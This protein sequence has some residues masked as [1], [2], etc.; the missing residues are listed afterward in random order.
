MSEKKNTTQTLA[1][2]LLHQ[3]QRRRRRY[4]HTMSENAT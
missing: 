3:S 4:A 1:I 2:P